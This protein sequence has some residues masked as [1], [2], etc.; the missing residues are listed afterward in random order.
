MP[1]DFPLNWAATSITGVNVI[2]TTGAQIIGAGSQRRGIHFH[3]PGT[4]TVYVYSLLQSPAPSLAAL[5]GTFVV[6]PQNDITLYGGNVGT[7]HA[8]NSAWGAFSASGSNNALTIMEM[9][10]L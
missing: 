7:L 2:T 4:V 8:V 1:A 9:T 6:F 5:G 3:N 10:G